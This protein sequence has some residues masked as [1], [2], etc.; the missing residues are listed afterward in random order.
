MLSFS[1]D[2]MDVDMMDEKLDSVPEG[3]PM[4]FEYENPLYFVRE[5]YPLYYDQIRELLDFRRMKYISV[6]GTPGTGKSIFY[7]YVFNRFRKEYPDKTIVTASFTKGRDL[8]EC[9]VFYPGEEGK[10]LSE[11]LWKTHT[12]QNGTLTLPI[13]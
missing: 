3:I 2:N 5:C 1:E 7:L 12:I 8:K 6:T 10:T 11:Q 9:V 4:A 13:G